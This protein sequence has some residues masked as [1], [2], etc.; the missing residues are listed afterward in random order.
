MIKL[1][2]RAKKKDI[3]HKRIRKKLSGTS[4]V[5]RLSVYKS[6]QNIYAQIIDDK[7][8]NTLIAAS[9]LTPEITSLVKKDKLNKVAAAKLVGSHIASV[10]IEKNISK[11]CFDRGGFP[12]TGRIKSLA[13]GA[14]E[15][16]LKL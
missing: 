12:Y 1:I 5:P 16:G 8:G 15:S 4:D 9:T 7:T 11:V 14:R 13:E 2:S 10:C 3:R 6:I